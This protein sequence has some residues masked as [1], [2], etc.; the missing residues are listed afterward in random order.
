MHVHSP[1]SFISFA[2]LAGECYWFS[3]ISMAAHSFV[4]PPPRLSRYA[5]GSPPLLVKEKD[6][7]P[8]VTYDEAHSAMSA[9]VLSFMQAQVIRDHTSVSTLLA[10]GECHAHDS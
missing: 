1:A 9:A 10:A 8:E 5:S 3:T 2:L 7:M 4:V 6:L